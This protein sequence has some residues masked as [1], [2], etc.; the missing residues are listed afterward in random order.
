LTQQE[1]HDD[2]VRAD[3]F[4]IAWAA[5]YNPQEFDDVYNYLW[6]LRFELSEDTDHAFANETE[7]AQG[8]KF[9]PAPGHGN[10]A[11]LVSVATTPTLRAQA[12]SQDSP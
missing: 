10:T 2:E 9:R 3:L 1:L 6:E 5:V 4:S 8:L 11:L 12:V 7:F